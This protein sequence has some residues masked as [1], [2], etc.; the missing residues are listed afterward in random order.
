MCIVK[1]IKRGK[2]AQIFS[3]VNTA[4]IEINEKDFKLREDVHIQKTN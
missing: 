1:Y 3:V 2:F 4:F